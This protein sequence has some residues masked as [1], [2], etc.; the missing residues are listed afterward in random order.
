MLCTRVWYS[1]LMRVSQNNVSVSFLLLS[2][3]IEL[4]TFSVVTTLSKDKCDPDKAVP[5]AS[6]CRIP[7]SVL[8]L[9]AETNPIV[10]LITMIV[11]VLHSVFNFLAF[12]NDISFWKDKK[13]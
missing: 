7:T 8:Q 12:K 10:L 11:S 9:L 4:S 2:L 3:S 5:L 1:I 13:R 6:P